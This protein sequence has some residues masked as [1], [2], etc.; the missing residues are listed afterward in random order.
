[1][2]K[3]FLTLR[4]VEK[5][6]DGILLRR[7]KARLKGKFPTC[8]YLGV[9]E[10][11]A[12]VGTHFHFII[13]LAQGIRQKTYRREVRKLFPEF[14][15][16]ALEVRGVKRLKASVDYILKSFRPYDLCKALLSGNTSEKMVTNL[17]I[18]KVLALSSFT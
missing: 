1:V 15:G 16:M 14:R 13:L 11:H 6:L 2:N 5:N 12:E 10:R 9:S 7:A 4:H 18:R 17:S 8:D 3:I